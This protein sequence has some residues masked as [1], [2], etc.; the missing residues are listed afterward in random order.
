[1]QDLGTK[2]YWKCSSHEIMIC[3]NFIVKKHLKEG[4]RKLICFLVNNL[5][6]EIRAEKDYFV[7]CLTIL[8]SFLH[9]LSIRS[10]ILHVEAKEGI[11]MTKI[12]IQD[13]QNL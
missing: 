7:T 6:V 13:F 5:E 4:V 8:F 12:S 1:M 10:A 11:N 3:G 2:K 9:W